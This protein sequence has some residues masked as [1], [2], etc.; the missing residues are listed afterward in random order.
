MSRRTPI[1][2]LHD[3]LSKHPAV[4]AW[5]TLRPAKVEPQSIHVLRQRRGSSLYRLLG[6]GFEGSSVIVKRCRKERG[7]IERTVYAEVLPHLPVTAPRYY[8]CREEDESCWLFLEDV[9]AERYLQSSEEHLALAGRWLALLHTSAAEIPAAASA[10]SRLPDGGPARYLE[11]LRSARRVLS[12]NFSHSLLTAEELGVLEGIVS[13]YDQLEGR[14]GRA[15]E[16]CE[17]VRCTLVHGDFRPKNAYTRGDATG[18]Q[19]F[20][21]DW[22]M[23]GWGPPAA[24]LTRVDLGAYKSVIK[25]RCPSVDACAIDRLAGVGQVFRFLAAINWETVRFGGEAREL[26][27]RPMSSITV[28]SERLAAA[29]RAAG[30]V[31]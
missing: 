22:E 12:K 20:P 15:E 29:V 14:W 21:I 19:L 27:I 4:E 30:L 31:D 17:G 18:V 13:L 26:L 1:E 28:L 23:A 10:A 6:V 7:A 16:A 8:G 5:S 24:D 2:V 25:D 11:H 9:G 3:D